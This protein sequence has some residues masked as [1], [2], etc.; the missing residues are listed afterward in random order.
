[1]TGCKR[2]CPAGKF[3]FIQATDLALLQGVDK[4]CAEITKQEHGNATGEPARVDLLCMSQGAFD[5]SPNQV[6]NGNLFSDDEGEGLL[7]LRLQIP[8]REL[9][10]A[11]PCSTIPA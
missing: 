2:I 7:T 1:M 9:N 3:C 10:S 5:F 6:T 11:I 4:A 8:R